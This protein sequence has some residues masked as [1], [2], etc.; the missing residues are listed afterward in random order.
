MTLIDISPE[1]FCELSES[2]LRIAADY[3]KDLSNRAIPAKGTGAEIE[4][5]FRQTPPEKGDP[6]EA[7]RGLRDTAL[8]SRAQNGRFFGYVLGSGEPA[9]AVVDLLCS[10]LNQNVTAWRSSP[11]AVTV[12]RTVVD[13]LAQAVGCQSFQGILTGGGSAANLMGL[14]M[15]REATAPANE[16]GLREGVAA[17]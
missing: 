16:C 7:L 2:V 13:W 10:V 4:Q 6:E 9:A 5:I 8:Y 3:L 1:E 12:E 11:A 15:A 17:A 14:A